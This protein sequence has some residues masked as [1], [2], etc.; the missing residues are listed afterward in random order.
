MRLTGVDH[1]L[2]APAGAGWASA[3]PLPQGPRLVWDR[4]PLGTRI[5]DPAA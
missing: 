4:C 1:L 2:L 5:G 3:R